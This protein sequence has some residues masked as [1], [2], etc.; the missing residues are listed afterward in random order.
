MI[1][2]G[3][4]DCQSQFK[5][6]IMSKKLFLVFFVL[7]IVFHSNAQSSFENEFL[8]IKNQL[9]LWDPVRGEWLANSILAFADNKPIPDRTFPEDFTPY[10]M[11]IMI[12]L[13]QRRE[14]SQLMT[15]SL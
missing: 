8:S 6:S 14:I 15:Q 5:V 11:A 13:E 7:N 1:W 9:N 10:Q 12:P 4:C 2:N 3:Y